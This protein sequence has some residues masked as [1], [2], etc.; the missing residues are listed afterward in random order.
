MQR[1]VGKG[2]QKVGCN[3]N[4]SHRLPH[5]EIWVGA[6][7]RWGASNC[8]ASFPRDVLTCPVQGSIL[9]KGAGGGWVLRNTHGEGL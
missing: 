3:R 5:S 4:K 8:P 2:G 7:D 6:G 1:Q 9:V